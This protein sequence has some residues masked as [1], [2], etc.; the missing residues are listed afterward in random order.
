[1]RSVHSAG[2]FSNLKETIPLGSLPQ[3]HTDSPQG[4]IAALPALNSTLAR[5]LLTEFKKKF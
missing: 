5:N 3:K 4:N 1:M 2:I